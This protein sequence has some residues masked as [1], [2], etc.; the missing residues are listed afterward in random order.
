MTSEWAPPGDDDASVMDDT[1]MLAEMNTLRA[2]IDA[3]PSNEFATRFALEKQL[4]E[5]RNRLHESTAD[6]LEA[7]GDEWAERAGRKGEHA[8]D[9]EAMKAR[10]RIMPAAG[11]GS[12]G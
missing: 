3:L 8:E 6:Q 11:G 7:A 9:T 5:L 10:A 4:D 1:A 12:P 2:R